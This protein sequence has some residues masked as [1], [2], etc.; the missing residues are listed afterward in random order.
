VL[1]GGGGVG[2]WFIHFFASGN[3]RLEDRR[4]D[5]AEESDRN[6]ELEERWL[7]GR[8]DNVLLVAKLNRMQWAWDNWRDIAINLGDALEK[9]E[10]IPGIIIRQLKGWPSSRTVLADVIGLSS[11]EKEKEEKD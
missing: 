3:V 9:K 4:K 5:K 6:K 10:D 7:E 2:A 1:A 11:D 8:D